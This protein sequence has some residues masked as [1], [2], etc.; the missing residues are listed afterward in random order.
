M[1]RPSSR[2]S[3][4][5]NL[6]DRLLLSA[7]S[8]PISKWPRA[9]TPPTSPP[10]SLLPWH[11]ILQS[12][13]DRCLFEAGL[14]EVPNDPDPFVTYYPAPCQYEDPLPHNPNHHWATGR[15]DPSCLCCSLV[16]DSIEAAKAHVRNVHIKPILNARNAPALKKSNRV[17][18]QLTAALR[19]YKLRRANHRSQSPSPSPCPQTEQQQQQ[20]QQQQQRQHHSA[21]SKTHK[22]SHTTSDLPFVNHSQTTNTFIP[23][24]ESHSPT[25]NYST[26]PS[27]HTQSGNVPSSRPSPLVPQSPLKHR[28]LDSPSPPVQRPASYRTPDE[29]APTSPIRPSSPKPLPIDHH[30]EPLVVEPR[31]YPGFGV[32]MFVPE[33]RPTEERRAYSSRHSSLSPS[34]SFRDIPN[35]PRKHP[36][37][38]VADH[39]FDISQSMDSS[40]DR[41]RASGRFEERTVTKKDSLGDNALNRT[42]NKFDNE[43]IIIDDDMDDY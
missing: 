13:N 3:D 36:K 6:F 20:P 8:R 43:V 18:R 27:N 1:C 9:S 35:S 12:Y 19:A 37:P 21:Q 31:H 10:P 11:H 29:T 17:P 26:S 22:P 33:S 2:P 4:S 16:F 41:A 14:S 28:I 34:P 24:F 40:P 15:P 5:L 38:V 7:L 23:S 39:C 42:R 32:S 25:P 30:S